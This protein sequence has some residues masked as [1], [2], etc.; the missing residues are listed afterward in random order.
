[1][2]FTTTWMYTIV[3]IMVG[4][5]Q[6]AISVYYQQAPYA[7]VRTCTFPTYWKT[8]RRLRYLNINTTA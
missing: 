1:M 5:K 3:R 4:V 8:P 2:A 7:D 6:A